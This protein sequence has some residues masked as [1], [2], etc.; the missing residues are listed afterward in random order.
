MPTTTHSELAIN[1]GPKAKAS[2][3]GTGK[4]FAGNELKYLQE[5]LE[6]N[7]LFYGFGTQVKEACR[8]MARYA[9]VPHVVPC[10]SGS[11]AIHLGLIAC[12]IGPGDE[13]ITTP[14]TDSG[15]VLG[16][17]EEGAVPVFC[18]PEL[19]MQPSAR[20][21]E[22]CITSRT[23]A[24]V[25]VHLA[26]YPA[27]MEEIVALCNARGIGVVEDCA[28]AWGARINGQLVGTFGTVGAYSTNDWKHISTGD[29]G[30]V[31]LRDE[32][33]YRRVSNYSDKHYDRLFDGKQRQAHQGL[34]Y[35]MSELQGAVARAQL[36]KVDDITG[37]HNHIGTLLADLLRPLR[38]ATM[39][40]PIPGGYSTYWWTLLLTDAAALT[41]TRDEVVAALQAEGVPANSH[42]NYDLV[43]K[44]LFQTR[45]VR[46]WLDEK[47]RSYPFDQPDGRSY[48]YNFDKLPRHRQML[49]TGITLGVNTWYTDT[50][51]REIAAGVLKVFDAF[52][53]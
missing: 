20:A 40:E 8:M 32:T 23:K 18:D 28:Q 44:P 52:A 30:F 53:K 51:V 26:G 25:V 39:V 10:S 15:T 42:Q 24:V 33:L 43:G 16:I 14:N 11:A 6:S 4:R 47:R 46:P 19:T 1:G 21:I 37:R 49:D 12:G 38:G 3:F 41:A 7:S 36:E 27:P 34:N 35:R 13:V 5:A 48:R 45:N 22:A 31:A 9:N 29:G 17:I 50:D 2:P